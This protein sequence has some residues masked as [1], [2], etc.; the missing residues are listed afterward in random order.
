[1]TAPSETGG[2]KQEFAATERI[3]A[4]QGGPGRGPMGGGMV[5]QKAMDFLPSAKRLVA[6]MRPDRGKALLVVAL[7]VVSVGLMSVGPRIL[8]HAT[9]LVFNGFIGSQ[10]PPGT[11]ESQWPEAVQGQDVVP[12]QGV[13]FTAV[14]DVLM[15]ALAIYAAASLLAWLQGFVLNTVV[16]NTVRQLR[17][18]VETKINR[19]PL[20]Y[21]DRSPRGELLSRV[22]NDIDNVSQ[23]L[24]QTMSQL[25]T[26]L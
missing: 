9:D 6:R 17:E 1:M 14:A 4:P 3:E 18:D 26:S 15:L 8:G 5:G 7:G 20:G 24:Q 19:L 10:I 12:G 23:T 13:D 11:P 2:R 16:Q 21:F 22:T 25:L